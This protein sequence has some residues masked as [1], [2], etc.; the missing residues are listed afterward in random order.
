MQTVSEAPAVAVND[1]SGWIGVRATAWVRNHSQSGGV[2]RLVLLVLATHAH[3]D[4]TEARASVEKLER[5]AG[6]S[7]RTVQKALRWGEEHGE[8]ERT[9]LTYKG[10]VVY[11]FPAIGGASQGRGGASHV[12]PWGVPRAPEEVVEEAVEEESRNRCSRVERSDA[13]ANGT[14][15]TTNVDLLLRVYDRWFE[16]KFRRRPRR[17]DGDVERARELAGMAV[18]VFEEVVEFAFDDEFS[19]KQGPWARQFPTVEVFEATEA[20]YR[21]EPP[22]ADEDDLEGVD[23][24]PEDDR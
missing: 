17:K 5:E 20:R 15:T 23:W 9:G 24:L 14:T 18:Y 19:V 16:R 6:V 1:S 22:T 2:T 13:H 11:S 3:D 10:V 12:R 8:I 4:G 21:G 7:R